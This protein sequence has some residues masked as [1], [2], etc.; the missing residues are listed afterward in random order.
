M[1]IAREIFMNMKYHRA[2]QPY[3]RLVAIAVSGMNRN[4]FLKK[5]KKYT[6]LHLHTRVVASYTR[7]QNTAE[8]CIKAF[9]SFVRFGCFSASR[10][11]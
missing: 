10:D 6:V 8:R 5:K 7:D 11:L 1:E 4:R 3:S 2:R 9:S